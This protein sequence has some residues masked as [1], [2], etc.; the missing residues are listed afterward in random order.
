LFEVDFFDVVSFWCGC[1]V[2]RFPLV[3][4]VEAAEGCGLLPPSTILETDSETWLLDRL[5]EL[6]TKICGLDVYE[7]ISKIK[8]MILILEWKNIIY[9]IYYIQ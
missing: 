6:T 7:N 9:N 8:I 4:V 1:S 2:A 3:L 5:F